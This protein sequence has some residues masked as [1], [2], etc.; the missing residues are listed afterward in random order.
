M[1]RPAADVDPRVERSRRVIMEATLDEL[2][3]VG[4]G[5]LTIES[6]ARRAGVGKATVYRH[7]DGKLDLV[8]DSL[9]TLKSVMHPPEGGTVR[10]RVLALLSALATAMG[11]SRWSSCLPAMISAAARDDALRRFHHSF[12]SERRKVLADLVQEGI[13]AGEVEPDA[14]PILVA[15]LL[16]GP[17]FYRRL[18]TAESYPPN[19][20]ELIVDAVLPVRAAGRRT[21]SRR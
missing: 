7:W 16:V 5:A 17:I 8:T 14:D 13:A 12:T 10:E 6:V 18:M 1:S 3:E 20:I 15:D 19:E 9:V 2:G 11:D 4:Y 21:H